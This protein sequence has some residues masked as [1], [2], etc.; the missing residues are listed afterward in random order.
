MRGINGIFL[1]AKV[2]VYH[3][4]WENLCHINC[5]YIIW[6][7]VF[8]YANQKSTSISLSVSAKIVN[9]YIIG[10]S[11]SHLEKA[12]V[13]YCVFQRFLEIDCQHQHQT[14]LVSNA[15]YYRSR[16]ITDPLS[17]DEGSP[18]HAF[19]GIISS[20]SIGQSA[21]A[22]FTSSKRNPIQSLSATFFVL[23]LR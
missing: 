15:C 7:G 2:H 20:M 13:T 16:E 14:Q 22:K 9:I 21:Q 8:L 3:S 19:K 18:S 23:T 10:L 5:R 11:A 12:W 1:Y 17:F 6:Y 4:V